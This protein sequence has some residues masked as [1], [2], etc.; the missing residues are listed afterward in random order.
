M[1]LLSGTTACGNKTEETTHTSY[2]W[3]GDT[4]R[5]SNDRLHSELKIRT[6]DQDLFEQEIKTPGTVRPITDRYAV[7][8][9]PFSGRIQQSYVRLGQQVAKGAP[10][11]S[12]HC[13]DFIS[14]Q[15]EYYQAGSEAELARKELRRKEDLFK[16]GVGTEKE[17]EE[18]QHMLRV[19]EK[20]LE[21]TISALH[22]FQVDPKS[23]VLGQPLVVYSPISGQIIENN[24]VTGQYLNDDAEPVVVVADLSQVWVTA[25]VKEK[26]LAF[27]RTGSD[28]EI[29]LPAF[30]DK[31]IEGRVFHIDHSVDENTRSVQVLSVCDNP[32]HIL[33]L[34]MYINVHLKNHPEEGIAVPVEALLQDE[35]N[36]FVFVQTKDDEFVKRPVVTG[37]TLDG[38]VMV[39]HGLNK[40][41]RIIAEGGYQLN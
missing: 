7:I 17:Y 38:I 24:V 11:F 3:I 19:A 28:M 26:D 5:I 13:A 9:P 39:S 41:E 6:V 30:P 31:V 33:R 14:A 10:L 36:T 40:G 29:M 4:V 27:V 1:I 25:Q 35:V 23:M 22:I 20:E 16:N 8:A 21:N 15:K 12:I 18:A 2:Q 32:D 34:G 37:P